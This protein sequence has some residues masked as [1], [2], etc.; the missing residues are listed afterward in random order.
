MGTRTRDRN[1]SMAAILDA[2]EE[3]FAEIGF[4]DA[5]TA[6]IAERAGV[7]KGLIHHH[8][9]SKRGL[10]DQVIDRRFNEYLEIQ[11]RILEEPGAGGPETFAKSLPMFFD[12]LRRN[13]R[14]VRLHA[15]ALA[16]RAIAHGDAKIAGS[17]LAQRGV[18]LIRAGQQAGRI[19]A[20][21]DPATALA[22]FFSLAE[23]WF[24]AR[25]DFEHRFG[26]TLPTDEAYVDAIT[27]I[28]VRGVEP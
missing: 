26:D 6:A 15:W 16:E 3:V 4:A 14:F 1:A 2:A 20:D 5:A 7:T 21:I 25:P 11:A 17:T 18:D 22:A 24:H 23:H 27:K 10:W 8:F 13:P 19:R 28:L 12:F 9:G